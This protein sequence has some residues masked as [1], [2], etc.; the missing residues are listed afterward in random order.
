M[1]QIRVF[2]LHMD[3]SAKHAATCIIRSKKAIISRV[4]RQLTSGMS[5]D[6][7]ERRVD[8]NRE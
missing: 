5:S 8:S 2:F 6:F 7:S 3:S 1:Q 4:N